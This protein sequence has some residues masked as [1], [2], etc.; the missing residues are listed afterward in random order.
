MGNGNN[1]DEKRREKWKVN[2][3]KKNKQLNEIHKRIHQGKWPKML[4]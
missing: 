3:L 1:V 4:N 2:K